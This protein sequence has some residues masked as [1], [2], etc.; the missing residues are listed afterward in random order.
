M[1]AVLL[2]ILFNLRYQTKLFKMIC[3]R[4]S[5]GIIIVVCSLQI[6][7]PIHLGLLL[8]AVFGNRV[9]RFYISPPLYIWCLVVYILRRLSQIFL[10]GHVMKLKLC[11]IRV[12]R[13]PVSDLPIRSTYLHNHPIR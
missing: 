4:V 2:S 6:S 5:N 10:V 12:P 8:K 11:K 7:F 1:I 3:Y 13:R 9:K